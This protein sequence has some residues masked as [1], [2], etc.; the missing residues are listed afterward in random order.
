MPML[1]TEFFFQKKKMK[2]SLEKFDCFYIFAQHIHRGYTLEPPRQ[3]DSNEYPQCM[4]WIQDTK[5]RFIPAN[6][7]FFYIKVGF[8]EVYMSRTFS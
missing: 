3:G 4:F 2:I 1:Y 8:K 7:I 6:P 5:I